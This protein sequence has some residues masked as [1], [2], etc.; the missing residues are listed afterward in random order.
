MLNFTPEK[1]KK[2]IFTACYKKW[3]WSDMLNENYIVKIL[4]YKLWMLTISYQIICMSKKKIGKKQH[5][6][7]PL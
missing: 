5:K 7:Q 3:F 6:Q 2:N 4:S 1:K